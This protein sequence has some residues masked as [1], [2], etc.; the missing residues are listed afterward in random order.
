M[1]IW[2]FP[3]AALAA[4]LVGT[5]GYLVSGFLLPSNRFPAARRWRKAVA[6]G[7]SLV[8]LYL[9]LNNLAHLD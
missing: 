2:G 3:F 8:F 5:A 9:Y 7:L 1:L 4:C 6:A